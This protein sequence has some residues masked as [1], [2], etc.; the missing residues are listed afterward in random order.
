MSCC[1]A[2]CRVASRRAV[3][4]C[5]VARCGAVCRGLAWCRGGS[6]EVSLACVGR[7]GLREILL[8]DHGVLGACTLT[9]TH[10][11]NHQSSPILRTTSPGVNQVLVRWVPIGRGLITHTG[12]PTLNFCAVELGADF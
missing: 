4:R 10:G 12:S 2:L 11:L 3:V 7:L 1:A 6:V 5:S 9:L 8:N